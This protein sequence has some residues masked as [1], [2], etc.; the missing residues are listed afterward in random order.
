LPTDVAKIAC[1][2]CDDYLSLVMPV[3]EYGAKKWR[4]DISC[5]ADR[6]RL[7]TAPKFIVY[8]SGDAD[9]C[10]SQS[11]RFAHSYARR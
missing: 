9:T 2:E 6:R 3:A 5:F 1:G 11:K 7:L 8:L 10:A 4:R